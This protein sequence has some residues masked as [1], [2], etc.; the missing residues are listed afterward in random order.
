[1]NSTRTT[2]VATAALALAIAGASL[3]R[4]E[5][6]KEL[7]PPE[8][9]GV[10][11]TEHL[12]GQIPLDLEF[13][14]SD[15]KKVRLRDYFNGQKPAILTLVYYR[16]PMLCSLVLKG[17]IEAI[18]EIPLTV[19]E[20]FDIVTVSIDPREMPPLAK[21]NKQSHVKEYGRPEAMK[22]WRF[23]TGREENIKKLADAVGFGYKYA[24]DRQEYIHLAVIFVATPEGR[25]SRYLYGIKFNPSTVRMALVEAGQGKTGSTMDRILLSCFHFDAEAG[26]YNVAAMR[27]MQAGGLITLVVLGTVLGLYW[28]RE[29]KRRRMRTEGADGPDG[30]S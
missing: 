9:E 8:L 24:E 6:R 20:D 26:K 17:M 2:N 21:L 3:A 16:C 10:E 13:V 12:N 1:M 28:R 29:S 4:G 22:G 5:Q 19:G 27:I 23:L 11:I 25:L 7:P 30:E 18:K 14:D 15:G